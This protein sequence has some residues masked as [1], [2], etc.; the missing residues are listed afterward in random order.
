M[1]SAFHNPD[2][3]LVATEPRIIAAWEIAS[4]VASGLIAEWVVLAFVGRSK[5]VIA[6]PLVLAAILMLVSHRAHA[7]SLKTIGFRFDNF[8]RACGLLALPTAV[9]LLLVIL[10]GW[11]TGQPLLA[12]PWRNR[13]ILL[14]FWAI[15][16]QYVLNGFVNRRA[17]IV[18]GKGWKSVLLVGL[19]FGLLHL[20][21]PLLALLTFIGGLIW[22]W[23]YQR[24]PNLFALALSHS[25]VS[26][27]LALTISSNLL[28][29]LRVGFKYF[30]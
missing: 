18:L 2:H 19:I 27:T 7:E 14:P 21:N 16:Q 3:E 8:W 10:I 4:I 25:I 26:V 15:F 24:Q 12:V 5:L 28:N 1:V 17:Q 23:A 29:S 11:L 30:G 22:G 9:A 13:F 6:I 20:P